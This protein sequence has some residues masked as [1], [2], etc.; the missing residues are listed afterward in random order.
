MSSRNQ[1]LSKSERESAAIIFQTLR[2]VKHYFPI[3]S[4]FFIKEMVLNIFD[5]Q[6]AMELEYFEIANSKN[7]KSIQRKNKNQ[8]Y[9]AFIAVVVNG[10]RLI[11]TISL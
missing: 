11:D 8:E 6:F 10:I 7:L 4:V 1:R 3:K 9:R 5:S 2:Q